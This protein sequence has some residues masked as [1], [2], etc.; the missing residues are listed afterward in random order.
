MTK[1][2]RFLGE[3]EQIKSATSQNT[4]TR[5]HTAWNQP[6]TPAGSQN[7]SSG[8]LLRVRAAIVKGDDLQKLRLSLDESQLRWCDAQPVKLPHAGNVAVA[9]NRTHRWPTQ[10]PGDAPPHSDPH[11]LHLV[12]PKIDLKGVFRRFLS[13][14]A[15]P[16][17]T[18]AHLPSFVSMKIIFNVK[19]HSVL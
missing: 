5:T 13:A 16:P 14:Q 9:K 12:P 6:H 7:S 1:Q 15:H 3:H 19:M 17:S 11:F 8:V 10:G 2:T 18:I 4:H